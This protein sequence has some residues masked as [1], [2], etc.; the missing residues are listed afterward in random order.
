MTFMKVFSSETSIISQMDLITLSL[1]NANFIVLLLH[2]TKTF[3]LSL[4]CLCF[5]V[6]S[7]T[8]QSLC[9]ECSGQ[10]QLCELLNDIKRCNL[11]SFATLV[12]IHCIGTSSSYETLPFNLI[13][14]SMQKNFQFQW[15]TQVFNDSICFPFLFWHLF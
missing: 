10:C 9:D 7:I 1:P 12:K 15:Y 14:I 6:G 5:L 3:S 8:M 4:H 2:S 13:T 11:K